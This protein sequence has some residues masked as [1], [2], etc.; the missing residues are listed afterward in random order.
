M[1]QNKVLIWTCL[2]FR[3]RSVNCIFLC[4]T[5][6]AV[7]HTFLWFLRGTLRLAV[8]KVVFED[9]ESSAFVI[10]GHQWFYCTVPVF[11]GKVFWITR[12][13]CLSSWFSCHTGASDLSNF[14]QK[15]LKQSESSSY[16]CNQNSFCHCDSWVLEVEVFTGITNRCGFFR[17][18]HPKRSRLINKPSSILVL[19]TNKG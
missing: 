16:C 17:K 12:E 13:T 10:F 6:I 4:C 18:E 14:Q 1:D 11:E 3:R 5:E 8:L 2:V 7:I 19:N 15:C 9:A